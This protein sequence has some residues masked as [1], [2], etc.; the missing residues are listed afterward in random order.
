MRTFAILGIL[1]LA[2]SQVWAHHSLAAEYDESKKITFTGALTAIDWR[3]PHGW[4]YLDVKDESGKVTKWQVELGSPNQMSRSGW[5]KDSV[6]IGE[7]IIVSNCNLAKDGSN[8]CS[9]RTFKFKDGR[10]VF[11]QGGR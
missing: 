10:T 3:N 11:S 4:L 2:S 5:N 1:T 6:K 7:E 8:T 9:S